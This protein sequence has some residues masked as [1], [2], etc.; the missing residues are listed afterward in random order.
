VLS[1]NG[2]KNF[3]SFQFKVSK[4]FCPLLYKDMFAFVAGE[5]SSYGD[6]VDHISRM[7]LPITWTANP[8]LAA[9]GS[10]TA[11]FT[12]TPIEPLIINPLIFDEEW[13]RK[14]GLCQITQFTVNATVDPQGLSRL[15]RQAS[16]DP[17]QY[18]SVIVNIGQ[19][20]LYLAYMTLPLHMSIPP[21]ISFPYTLVQNFTFPGQSA[22]STNGN[23]TITSNTLQFQSIPHKI[24]IS[25]SKLYN[26]KT[27]FD[28][29]SFLPI[30]GINITWGN[31]SGILST[32]GQHDLYHVCRKNGLQQSWAMFHGQVINLYTIGNVNNNVQA[33]TKTF[34]GPA[35]P[36]ALEFGQDI[37][38]LVD[39]YPGKQESYNFQCQVNF[40]DN[41][42]HTL[43]FDTTYQPQLDIIVLYHGSVTIAGGNITLNT[44]IVPNMSGEDISKLNKV[45]FPKETD[46]Y[47]GGK[48]DLGQILTS[49]PGRIFRG[50]SGLV[51]GLFGSDEYGQEHPGINMEQV[52][53]LAKK[54]LSGKKKKRAAEEE[55][56]GLS[57]AIARQ[58]RRK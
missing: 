35:A 40:V 33:V 48:F 9:G 26:Q 17:V 51:S 38:L 12:V 43:S 18:S 50:I 47:S 39:D 44:G 46:V 42:D 1:K 55:A 14:P 31:T 2:R 6:Q 24:I 27:R 3:I 5:F 54:L 25:V 16:N 7:N 10:S 34:R 28:S 8:S 19:P 30:T 49:I 21:S 45:S 22:I 20:I 58:L 13:W 52:M 41:R 11:T 56:E 4:K 15:W 53:E 32:L 29:D 36:I 37:Q 23:Y 57:S